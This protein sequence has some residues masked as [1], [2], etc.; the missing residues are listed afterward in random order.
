MKNALFA[1]IV[2]CTFPLSAQ[3]I[4]Q[5]FAA[6]SRGVGVVSDMDL[7]PT[8][9]GSILIAMPLLLSPDVTVLSVTDNAPDGSNTYRKVPGA[10]S[11]CAKQTLDIWYCEKCNPG[12]T[13]LKFHLSAHVTASINAFMEV[14]GLAQT[15]AI[16][17]S[18][19]HLSDGVGTSE[20]LEVGP[21]VRT[22]EK[23]FIIARYFSTAPLPTGVSLAT[24]KYTPSYVYLLDGAPGT[25]QPTLTGGKPAGKFCMS[26]AA[27][28]TAP[29]V[30]VSTPASTE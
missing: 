15:A 17:G 4:L 30:A 10:G 22:T 12:V 1:L 29:V 9:R 14:S 25:Y 8:S 23:D 3:T 20:G 6:V 16:D 21:S 26:M 19:V 28:K 24:W 5:Q 27:F 11:S 13:E 2:F 7:E 18:G